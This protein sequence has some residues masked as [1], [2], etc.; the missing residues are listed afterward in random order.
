VTLPENE[1]LIAPPSNCS[2]ALIHFAEPKAASLNVLRT[3]LFVLP[4]QR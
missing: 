2:F 3:H 1:E 4:A